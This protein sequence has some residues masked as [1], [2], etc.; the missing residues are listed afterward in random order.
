MLACLGE[1]VEFVGTF[2]PLGFEWARTFTVRNP[3]ADRAIDAHFWC[4]VFPAAGIAAEPRVS[5]IRSFPD[6]PWETRVRRGDDALP[7]DLCGPGPSGP[8]WWEQE[9]LRAALRLTEALAGGRPPQVREALRRA[10]GHGIYPLRDPDANRAPVGIDWRDAIPAR[11]MAPADGRWAPFARHPGQVDWIAAGRL[12]LATFLSAQLAWT[13]VAVGLDAGARFRSRWIVRS[14]L[15]VIYL[16][17]AEHVERRPE[18]GVGECGYCGGPILRTRREGGT[19]NRW[20][21]GCA[22]AGRQR[23]HRARGGTDDGATRPA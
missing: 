22:S 11:V 10:A 23:R 14:L 9:D 5:P 1:A 20:H 16:Q 17:L 12:G 19:G 2:G 6:L 7:H 8:L 3:G 13:Q 15:E 4:V 21:R 18:L